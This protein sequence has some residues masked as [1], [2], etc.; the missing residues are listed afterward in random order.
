MREDSVLL[1]LAAAGASLICRRRRRRSREPPLDHQA[2]PQQ[3]IRLG[4]GIFECCRFRARRRLCHRPGHCRPRL[5]HCSGGSGVVPHAVVQERPL[6]PDECL[7]LGRQCAAQLG[8]SLVERLQSLQQHS[9]TARR[10]KSACAAHW[11]LSAPPHSPQAADRNSVTCKSLALIVNPSRRHATGLVP[12]SRPTLLYL[13]SSCS[14]VASSVLW[15]IRYTAAAPQVMIMMSGQIGGGGGGAGGSEARLH[16]TLVAT[17]KGTAGENLRKFAVARTR[18]P[19]TSPYRA[20]LP[21]DPEHLAVVPERLFVS[22]GQ[23]DSLPEQGQAR[24]RR[25]QL[26]GPRLQC[27]VRRPQQLQLRGPG[28][29]HPPPAAAA[30]APSALASP[31]APRTDARDSATSWS[32]AAGLA[33][34]RSR[35]R[36]PAAGP[37]PPA[38]P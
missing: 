11:R 15:R 5:A 38:L 18:G 16:P 21:A 3:I 24:L 20:E 19:G 37:G 27:R 33:G 29:A 25:P 8:I 9:A 30:G 1:T 6:L 22:A 23:L 10:L 26:S 31:G 34:T 17:I 7:G 4:A 32:A 2:V 36:P 35:L 12:G 13:P 14:S 28:G